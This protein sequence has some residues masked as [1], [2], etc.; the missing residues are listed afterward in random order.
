MTGGHPD[1]PD[2]ERLAALGEFGGPAP[3][4]ALRIFAR[5]RNTPHERHAIDVL[6]AADART[7]LP[8]AVLLALASTLLDRGDRPNALRVLA[9]A[10]SPGGLM[11][12]ADLAWESGDRANA[13]ALVEQVL[14]RDFDWPGARERHERWTGARGL[15]PMPLEGAWDK[16]VARRL[17]SPF[18][19]LREVGRGG[20]AAV[21]EAT[22]RALGRRVALKV[23]HRPDRDRAQ[24]L[25]E[26]RVAVSLSGPGIVRIF[27]VDPQQGWLALEWATLGVLETL[28][29]TRRVELLAP[30]RR[31]A[32]PLAA[33][34]ARVH[35]AGWVH[36]DVKPANVPLRATDGPILSDFGIARR[37]GEPSP[38]GSAGYVSP[39]RLAGR[40]SD[41]RDDAY[42]YGRVLQDA[43]EAC[44]AAGH[45]DD[46]S[47]GRWRSLAATCTGH[48]AGRPKDGAALLAR[49]TGGTGG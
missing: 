46:V 2:I 33:A 27:D 4:E 23:Y 15:A 29:R 14:L 39:E 19:L 8:D 1:L 16:V 7:S 11:L 25:H 41:P 45:P 42:G 18:E 12:S 10:T 22:D 37:I 24:L 44:T 47:L 31:W 34:L 21:Y 43:L 5:L 28:I 30:L 20:T 48:D 9:R 49:A 35:A 17:E 38:P 26:T 40:A 3:D 36:H 13:V 6:L 32:I